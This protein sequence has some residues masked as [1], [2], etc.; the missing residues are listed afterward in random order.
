MVL[1]VEL[2]LAFH[3]LIHVLSPQGVWAIKGKCWGHLGVGGALGSQHRVSRLL[4]MGKPQ[5]L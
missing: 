3:T 2:V 1:R 4:S 5:P